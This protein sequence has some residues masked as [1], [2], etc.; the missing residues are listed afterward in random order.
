MFSINY[1]KFKGCQP[2]F[3]KTHFFRQK[4]LF[5]IW[6][7]SFSLCEEMGTKHILSKILGKRQDWFFSGFNIT[8]VALS[9]LPPLPSFYLL[10]ILGPS[11]TRKS[12]T[13]WTNRKNTAISYNPR[14]SS[15]IFLFPT[16]L[17]ASHPWILLLLQPHDEKSVYIRNISPLLPRWSWRQL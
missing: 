7:T 17:G 2:E 6:F 16:S 3:L 10:W 8:Y 12:S 14:C 4:R 5:Q 13:P 15:D 11:K 9:S 1:S